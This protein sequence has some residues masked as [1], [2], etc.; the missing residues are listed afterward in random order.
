MELASSPRWN[1]QGGEQEGE[2][3]GEREETLP[4]EEVEEGERDLRG[5]LSPIVTS[6]IRNELVSAPMMLSL[7]VAQ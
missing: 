5:T 4:A 7:S 6:F 1:V 2:E 3:E